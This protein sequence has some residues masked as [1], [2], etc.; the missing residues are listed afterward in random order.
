[1]V[2]ASCKA[3]P[4]YCANNLGQCYENGTGVE[5]NI[6]EAIKWYRLSAENGDSYG[7]L[8]LGDC[9]RDGHKTK[10]GEHWEKDAEAYYYS[11]SYKMGYHRV[12]DY[13]TLIKQDLDSAKYYWR[14]SATQGN[15]TAK[16]RL[17][18]IY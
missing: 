11:W 5:A 10:V 2:S 8:N 15:E 16:E 17:Q 1:M 3:E 6:R 9:F 4:Q 13:E 12:D 7:Q 18:K 14:L